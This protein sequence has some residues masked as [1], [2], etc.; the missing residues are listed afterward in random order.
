MAQKTTILRG[1]YWDGCTEANT[2]TVAKKINDVV[3]A[4]ASVEFISITKSGR[5]IVACIV[6]TSA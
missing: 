4:A 3:A 1:E 5:Q 6:W 2:T